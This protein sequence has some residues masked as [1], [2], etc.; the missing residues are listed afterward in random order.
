MY[1]IVYY[2][3]GTYF[4]ML[5]PGFV[6]ACLRFLLCLY[7]ACMS[8]AFDGCVTTVMFLVVALRLPIDRTHGGGGGGMWSVTA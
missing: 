1:T 8:V 7:G 3:L 4:F 6:A 5:F 2:G